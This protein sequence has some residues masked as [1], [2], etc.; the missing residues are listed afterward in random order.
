MNRVSFLRSLQHDNRSYLQEL[1][2]EFQTRF[3][4][5]GF[6]TTSVTRL[7]RAMQRQILIYRGDSLIYELAKN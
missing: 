2:K 6:K 1:N 3:N 5:R 4:D 7:L